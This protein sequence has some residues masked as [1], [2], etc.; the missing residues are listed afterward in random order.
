[1]LLT[2]S[3]LGNISLR[4]YPPSDLH[5]LGT[6][7][8]FILSQD[9]TLRQVTLLK[10]EFVPCFKSTDS[11]PPYGGSPP[12][13]LKGIFLVLSRMQLLRCYILS[14]KSKVLLP[15]PEGLLPFS[16][17]FSLEPL[18]GVHCLSKTKP[19]TFSV[20]GRR[21]RIGFFHRPSSVIRLLC[22][23]KSPQDCIPEM[24]KAL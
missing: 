18:K 9:Q 12:A 1:M 16:F 3:P 21:Q 4:T 20:G 15:S 11:S 7:P 14:E 2:R 8:A 22:F 5:V 24:W 17:H 13:Q 19:P 23:E 10:V 6:P